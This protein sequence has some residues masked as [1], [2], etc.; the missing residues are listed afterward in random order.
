MLGELSLVLFGYLAGSI[1][2]AFLAARR[3]GV[4]LRA[5]GSGNLGAS[6]VFRTTGKLVG[7]WVALLDV[8]KGVAVVMV[9]D[10]FDAGAS[11]RTTCGL[12]A[13]VGHIY[14]V[15]LGFRGGKGVA[16]TCGV[17]A[18]LAPAATTWL[19]PFF[20]AALWYTRYVSLASIFTAAMLG[21]VIYLTGAS[22]DVVVGGVVAGALVVFRHRSNLVRLQAGTERRLGQRA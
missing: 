18:V 20:A 22:R 5:A 12:S 21:P 4:D 6:N 15:W 16:T 19:A 2:I 7:F 11:L 14:P 1:P 8:L 3:R 9:A 10:G 17:F 13:I